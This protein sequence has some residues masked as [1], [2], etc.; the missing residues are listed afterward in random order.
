L[1]VGHQ[2]LRQLCSTCHVSQSDMNSASVHPVATV[3]SSEVPQRAAGDETAADNALLHANP[4]I[5]CYTYIPLKYRHQMF[6]LYFLPL[7]IKKSHH[8]LYLLPNV[9]YME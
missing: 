9:F 6:K 4:L 1:I 8:H 5:N 2:N 7:E 3:Q